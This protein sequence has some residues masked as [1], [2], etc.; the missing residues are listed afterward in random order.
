MIVTGRLIVDPSWR[1]VVVIVNY[2]FRPEERLDSGAGAIV[3]NSSLEA[4]FCNLL[5]MI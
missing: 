1:L 5:H 4:Q 2:S 3:L